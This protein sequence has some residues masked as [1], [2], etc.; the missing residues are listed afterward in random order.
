MV[1]FNIISLFFA[2]SFLGVHSKPNFLILFV[3]DLGYNEIN[4]KNDLI[5]GYTGYGDRVQTPHLEQLA[6]ESMVFTQWYSAWH[7][8][9]A[10]R[11]SMMTGRLPPRTG[12][13]SEGSGVFT[14][15]AIG[16]LPLNETTYAELLKP[17]GYRTAM[18]GKWH[19]GTREKFMPTNRGFDSYFGLP[20]SADMG[21]SVWKPDG[22]APY[23]PTPLPL[24][25]GNIIKKVE[26][27]EQP[28]NLE[29]LTIQYVTQV[30]NFFT[31]MSLQ[32]DPFVLYMSFSH[33]HNPQ[34]CG[35]AWCN[36]TTVKGVSAAIPTG[37]GG[38]G[39]AIEEMDWSIGEIMTALQTSGLDS[40]TLTFFTSDNGA[41]SNHVAV[42]DSHGSNAPLRGFK[43]SIW[44]GGIRMP[45]MVR[46]PGRIRGGSV[47]TQLVA[48]YDIFVTM[49]SLANVS[50][51][52][53]R[54][55]DGI[56]I[57][58]IL[59]E[60]EEAKG[61]ECLIIYHAGSEGPG[62]VRCGDYKLYFNQ[63]Q[64]GDLYN[65]AMD[66]GENHPINKT[67]SVWA[68]VVPNIT[69]AR[70]KHL[71]TM[72][73]VVDQIGLGAD[74]AYAFCADPH[75]QEKYPHLPN[76]TLT[77]ENWIA[78]WPVPPPPPI[79]PSSNSVGCWYDKGFPNKTGPCDLPVVKEGHCPKSNNV[80]AGEGAMT[81]ELCNTLCQGYEFFGVQN[82]GT[83]CFCGSHY[84][85]YSQAP[86][87]CN[88]TCAGNQ[89]EICGGPGCNSIYRTLNY[90][91]DGF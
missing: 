13:D 80:T 30:K 52:N 20:F 21:L 31:E 48:T 37:H 71:A 3:D 84:G 66:I 69:Q 36:K 39:S 46:W 75:S 59:F 62:A 18:L 77:P 33:V 50:L 44:E 35:V 58:P 15:E 78:P 32:K 10:S 65:L 41:P 76:C 49:M 56:D 16:G 53:D 25:K 73:K 70:E 85:R 23:Q 88:M 22:S 6:K 38:T 40:D 51:P 7:C 4:L 72:V 27:I 86:S 2:S 90:S 14:A 57:S 45:A 61:H 82:G 68:Q 83:G 89:S 43:G 42:Q 1:S 54:V 34:F 87:C 55:Y 11:A 8:C 26:I 9:S 19:L 74:P 5:P 24:I 79:V 29:N 60:H 12:V 28:A 17:A 47:S 81:I 67:S 63:N 64:P 91:S